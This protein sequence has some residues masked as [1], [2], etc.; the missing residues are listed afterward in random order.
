[1]MEFKE[2]DKVFI[3]WV[4]GNSGTYKLHK[5]KY[6]HYWVYMNTSGGEEV[7]RKAGEVFV[8]TES[9]ELL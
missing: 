6:G 8:D 7:N 3:R 9:V 5:D 1:M 2:G 4:G